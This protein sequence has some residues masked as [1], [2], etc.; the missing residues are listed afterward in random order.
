VNPTTPIANPASTP[1]TG[2]FAMVRGFLHVKGGSVP[3][4]TT[5]IGGRALKSQATAAGK[6]ADRWSSHAWGVA[7]SPA[8][9]LIS[10]VSLLSLTLGL[11][12]AAAGAYA[13]LEG[14]PI[15]STAPGLP[16]G[17]VY[18]EASP[19]NTN[20]NQAGA[21]TLDIN[22]IGV[23]GED[24]YALASASGDSVLFEG[25]GPMGETPSASVLFFV[26]T[27]TS[28]GWRTRSVL[29]RPQQSANEI[30]TLEGMPLYVDPSPDLSHA[31]VEANDLY[32]LAPLPNE[33][34]GE[35]IYL[36]GSDP[37]VVAT[38]LER[39]ET[40]N[41]VAICQTFNNA[42]G[43]PVG[44]SPDFS[45]VYFTYPGTLLPEDASRAAY[46]GPTG[47]W[48]FY[49]YSEGV[50]R[51]A[52]VLPDDSLDPFGAV[53]AASG[54]EVGV[55][56]PGDGVA[57]SGNQVSA[58]GSRAF[59]LSPDPAGVGSCVTAAEGEGQS[60]AQAAAVCAPQL[61]VRESGAKTLL[62]S[63]DTLLPDVGG[64]PAP[65]P[66]DPEGS[67]ESF[68]FASQDG[69][70]AF[71]ESEDQ[72]TPGAPEGPPGNTSKKMYDFDV[73]TGALTY[74]PDVVGTIVAT[75][76][77]GSSV[78]FVRPEGGGSPTELDLWSAGL[79]GGSVTPIVQLPGGE[80][81]SVRMSSDGSVVVFSTASEIPG[82]NDPAGSYLSGEDNAV[83]SE[84][85]FR[86][87]AS[88]N[89]LGCVS[90]APG[91]VASQ[92]AS[93]SVVREDTKGVSLYPGEVD[94][95]GMSA[96]GDRVFF[97]TQAPLVPQDTNTGTVVPGIEHEF[98]ELQGED[99][100]EW[101]NGVVYLISSGESGRNS[102]FLDN[103]ESG[104]DVFFAT[105]EGLVAGDTDG[106]YSVYDA[107]V[108][109]PGE[110]TP[111]AVPCEGSVCQGPPSVPSPLTPP[112]SAT[113]SGLGNPSPEPTVTPVT[114]KKTTTKTVK[115]KKGFT[116]KKSKCIKNK[117]KAKAKK[118]S[119]DRR[120]K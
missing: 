117:K 99:V 29:P 69:S 30:G 56:G 105:T 83:A 52:G 76:T 15:F 80:A 10:L 111:A 93:M 43:L 68:A 24:R 109:Q 20:G 120:V 9:L 26:A 39:P 107:R 50:L 88:T 32:T 85:I 22:G 2:L 70:Q 90:C 116:K 14:P 40:A 113:F 19:A 100:Y 104:N 115:C 7:I 45:T 81:G 33:K 28:S 110:S 119:N 6:L 66:A 16:D 38:W 78:A 62:V 54:H 92:H 103:S 53:P 86:Y 112:A 48:G 77:D 114:A 97:Q 3:S 73:D 108:P 27:R 101:E 34:C 75:D 89:T 18:E 61:Y 8:V 102:Y 47:A 60:P 64:L 63:E 74:L 67:A 11:V 35:Q 118:A 21:S 82:F 106:G 36:T 42:S 71:F 12:P 59:F 41:P 44:G 57:L 13:T 98:L 25:T 31:M 72:L 79:G 94:E 65:A 49:E 4:S 55:S 46:A 58:D 96:N 37:F 1:K 5:A 84:Q 87:D 17:R 91:G 23:P 51:S 95:R